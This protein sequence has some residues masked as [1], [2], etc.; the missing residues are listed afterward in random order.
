MGFAHSARP[1]HRAVV[2]R[3]CTGANALQNLLTP[4]EHAP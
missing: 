4:N 1:D 2:V 3:E